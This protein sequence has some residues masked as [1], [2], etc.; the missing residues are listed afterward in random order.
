MT[1]YQGITDFIGGLAPIEIRAGLRWSLSE[2]S[3]LSIV[4]LV[5]ARDAQEDG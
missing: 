2:L 3:W 1:S 4:C 5:V